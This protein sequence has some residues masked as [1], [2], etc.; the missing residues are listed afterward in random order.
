MREASHSF[1]LML[2][3]ILQR[4]ELKDKI[5]IFWMETQ[6]NKQKL[7]HLG[8]SENDKSPLFAYFNLHSPNKQVLDPKQKG[9]FTEQSI[10][11]FI[12]SIIKVD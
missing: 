8:F 3:K 9:S 7:K 11:H 5:A 4:R 12:K 10:V 6:I 2:N 1:M